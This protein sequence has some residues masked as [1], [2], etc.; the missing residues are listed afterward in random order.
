MENNICI[1]SSFF[2][3][4]FLLKPRFRVKRAFDHAYQVMIRALR[5]QSLPSLLSFIIRSNDP[6]F[7][8]R[9]QMLSSSVRP[10]LSTSEPQNMETVDDCHE[11]PSK[12]KKNEASSSGSQ[13]HI[14]NSDSSEK[15]KKKKF[16][17]KHSVSEGTETT[18]KRT[19]MQE[20]EDS[21]E[22]EEEEEATTT[23]AAGER[24]RKRGARPGT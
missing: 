17:T 19:S 15:R 3:F 9:K 18:S 1:I 7:T 16:K 4:T 24:K 20:G 5:Q 21:K 6:M 11:K 14:S 23:A 22:E 10:I 2:V 12:N 8:A 13:V